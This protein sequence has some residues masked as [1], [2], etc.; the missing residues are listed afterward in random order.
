MALVFAIVA[1]VTGLVA[2]G[3]VAFVAVVADG[4]GVCHCSCS[5]CCCS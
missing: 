3:A 1:A 2:H 4:A 5:Y